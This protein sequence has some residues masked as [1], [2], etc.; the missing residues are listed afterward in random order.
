MQPSSTMFT[1]TLTIIT[2]GTKASAVGDPLPDWTTATSTT[3][4]GRLSQRIRSEDAKQRDAQ[5]GEW[6]AYFPGGTSIDGRCRVIR[7]AQ[8]F[9]VIGPPY[10]PTVA[11]GS[12][13]HLECTL[14][15]VEG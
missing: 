12:P 2:P 10:E 13:T 7:G 5:I 8:T 4:R 14:R 15:L 6:S 1:D 11:G 3:V 9:D